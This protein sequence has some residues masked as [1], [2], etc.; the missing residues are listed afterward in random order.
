MSSELAIDGIILLGSILGTATVTLLPYFKRVRESSQ[1]DGSV[2]K[3]DKKFLYTALIAF[4]LGTIFSILNFS[5]VEAQVDPN[6]TLVKIF[7]TS[8]GI[9]FT[10]NWIFNSVLKPDSLVSVVS[11]LQ[12][13]NQKLK[14]K[15]ASLGAVTNTDNK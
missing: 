9:A 12:E 10:A 4:A 3:F 14:T 13:E 7:V 15:L 2:L 8:F 11:V 6:A 1:I 5:E